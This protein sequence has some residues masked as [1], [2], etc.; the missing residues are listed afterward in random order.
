MIP[1]AGEHG[2]DEVKSR[3]IASRAYSIPISSPQPWRHAEVRTSGSARSGVCLGRHPEDHRRIS[4]HSPGR[5]NHR[6]AIHLPLLQ[7]FVHIAVAV[8]VSVLDP[9][10]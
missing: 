10:R 1:L 9:H 4:R 2:N 7:T 6:T 8:F 3:R 5:G